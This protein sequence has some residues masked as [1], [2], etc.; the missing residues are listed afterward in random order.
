V[1]NQSRSQPVCLALLLVWSYTQEH[2]TLLKD[3]GVEASSLAAGCVRQYV[4]ALSRPMCRPEAGRRGQR[5][6]VGTNRSHSSQCNRASYL[7]TLQL[8]QLYRMHFAP[9]MSHTCSTHTAEMRHSK[10]VVTHHL[11]CCEHMQKLRKHVFTIAKHCAGHELSQ[12]S[13]LIRPRRQ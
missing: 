11:F 9:C 3:C 5:G 7:E 13:L 1:H 4:P 2:F 10:A 12:P 6:I 8:M